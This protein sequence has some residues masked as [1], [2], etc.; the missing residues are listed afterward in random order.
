VALTDAQKVSIK[1]HLGLNAA[2][3]ALYPFVDVFFSVEEVLSTLPAATE[4]EVI[5][6][7]DRLA[8]LETS[9]DGASTQRLQAI[10]VG[11]ITLRDDE[12]D[13]LWREVGRWRRELS[14][15]LGI[16][17]LNCGGIVVT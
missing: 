6:L 16:P 15:I 7:L 4:T 8:A 9:L 10:K 1:R 17:R 3:G 11:S 12:T 2:S 14:T 5:A 13:K